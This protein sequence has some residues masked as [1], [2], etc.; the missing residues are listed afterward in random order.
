MSEDFDGDMD[1]S[2]A[3]A[4]NTDVD[5]SI[6]PIADIPVEQPVVTE[7]LESPISEQELSELQNEAEALEIQPYEEPSTFETAAAAAMSNI[8]NPSFGARAISA[9]INLASGG[10][11]GDPVGSAAMT[12]LAQMAIDGGKVIGPAIGERMNDV[13]GNPA[14][15][16]QNIRIRQAIEEKPPLDD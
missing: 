11:L 9:G 14:A 8:D 5:I 15:D 12:Q 10:R 3:I 16:L 7:G 4:A 13:Y 6:E 1:T 2:A